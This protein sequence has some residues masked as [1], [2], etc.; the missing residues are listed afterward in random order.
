MKIA[1]AGG[2][3]TVGRHVTEMLGRRG[4]EPVVLARSTGFDLLTGAG[5][6]SA[7]EGVDGV[8][9][10]VSTST[11]SAAASTRFFGTTTANLLRAE[12]DAGVRH[13]VSLSI[14]NASTVGAG[15]YAG[16]ALQEERVKRGA[17]PWSMLRA[18]QF[19]EFAAQTLGGASRGFLTLVPVMRTQPVA[20]REV[21]ERLVEI[22]V[23]TPRGQVPDLGGP[24]E[25]RLVDMVRAYARA[26]R[27]RTRVVQF[28]LPGRMGTAMR[29]GA[30]LPA[31]GTEQGAQSFTQWLDGV[32]QG[33][34][35]G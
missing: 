28:K 23:S 19:H 13:H 6:S 10:V 33:T 32:A 4:H 11:L 34:P 18:T 26:T 1:I 29:D 12:A 24:R 25:E 30:L 17:V 20:A 15:Y 35:A 14:V 3:G 21:A 7:L 31:R 5:L 9:D 2:T 8:I 22:A 16:K 27:I